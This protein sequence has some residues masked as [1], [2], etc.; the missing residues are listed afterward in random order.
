M[1]KERALACVDY[2]VFALLT[3]LSGATILYF[4]HHWFTFGDL[5]NHS[6]I[7]SILTLL[8]LIKIANSQARWFALLF[9]KRPQPAVPKAGLRV[10]VVT[11]IVPG[12]ESLEMLERT[13]KALVT[14]DYPHDT[15]VLD[16]AD[17]KQVQ[18]LCQSLGAL[19][20]SRKNLSQYQT[21]DGLF[22]AHSKHGNYN[23]W[24]HETGFNR[25]DIIA[26]FDPDHVAVRSF[27]KEV[28]GYFE[29][30][31]TGYVQAA[32]VYYNQKANFIARGA[33]EETYEYN[34]CTQMAAYSFDQ[35]AVVG[36]H[37]VHRVEALKEVGGFAAHDADDLLI[38]LRYQ[39]R[40]WRGVYVPQILAQGLTP[41]D[42]NGYLKQQL[43]WARSVL[44][45]KCRLQRLVGKNM[46]PM[47]QVLS[48]LHGIFYLQNSFT[49]FLG[50]LVL[51]YFLISGDVPQ[52]ISQ[53]LL[54][55]LALLYAALQTCVFYRQTFYL[56]PRK[57]WGLHWRAALL[58]YAKW[59]VF[60]L[61]LWDVAVGRRVPY[62]LTSKVKAESKSSLLIIP[63]ALII[64][65]V[66]LA[67]VTGLLLGHRTTWLVYVAAAL[68]AATSLSLILT[69]WQRFPS[70]YDGSLLIF[71]QDDRKA[72]AHLDVSRLQGIGSQT[73]AMSIERN[74]AEME[75]S[76]ESHWRRHPGTSPFKLRRRALTVRHCLHVLPGERILEL[77]AGSGLWTEHL[78]ATLRGESSITAAVFNEELLQSSSTDLANTE[79]VYVQSLADLPAGQFDYIV[80][81]LILSH[82]LYPQ[83]L[84]AL[85]RLLKPGGQVLF[86]EPN[87]WNPQVL[88]KNLFRPLGRWV[89]ATLS[90][91]GMR[92]YDLMK[93]ASHQGFTNIEI[94]PYDIIHPRLPK[95]LLPQVQ[96]ASFL[97]EHACLIRELCG[98]LYIWLTKPATERT[99]RSVPKLT[100]HRQLYDS[101]SVVI[102]CHNEEMN[103]PS[104]VETLIGMYDE[105]LHEIIIVNDNSTDRTAEVTRALA[106]REPRIRLINRTPPGGVG[107][108]L[109]DGYAAATGRYILTMDCDFV[110]I[111]PELRDLFDAVASGR[112]GAIGSRFSHESVLI[113]YP[114]FKVLCNRGV[115]ALIKLLLP[116]RVRDTSNNLKLYRAEILK[117]LEI[118]ANHFAANMETGLKPILS[119]YDIQEVPMSWINRTAEMGSSSFKLLQVG[120]G[121]LSALARI[122]FKFY[123]D[124]RGFVSK[125][126]ED[127][128]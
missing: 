5:F 39:A 118:E 34:S 14:M 16:E 55:K 4:L 68:V 52:A 11:T 29:A 71:E 115:H 77:G 56:A 90:D 43:R 51:I 17:D 88:L 78:T 41:V 84:G 67:L 87:Y 80:G 58:R 27:L 114:F 45:I 60:I 73:T 10:G 93:R 24:L 18:D 8:V 123:R 120:P 36:C 62:A 32:Q 23:A 12:A 28:L 100:E 1:I 20:F 50:I 103:I 65:S 49:T 95:S 53:G 85:Y 124:K 37:N 126:K 127:F 31:A 99:Q 44:D 22:Q 25:Y 102:P 35:P 122:V 42:W 48:A 82:K 97:L 30:P 61:A 59:P 98:T 112:D 2:V 19:H 104:L 3:C 107:R 108:A 91:A 69:S 110:Q 6:T 105:Y 72:L 94:I 63:H 21:C 119:G 70:P 13:L 106:D 83:T 33:A 128:Q 111:V 75:L 40:G 116:V 121:Y 79:F 89:G 46:S 117:N 76:R 26:A 125:V 57:E 86:F 47:G 101:T 54:P 74:L 96:S 109:K 66:C 81:T 64:V 7:F 15:W 113:N 92:R 38:G 9:M